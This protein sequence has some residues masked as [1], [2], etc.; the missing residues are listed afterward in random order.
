[1]KVGWHE[2]ESGRPVQVVQDPRQFRT[3]DPRHDAKTW[4]YRTTW[5][6]RKG[7][8]EKIENR[9]TWSN[10]PNFKEIIKPLADKAIFRFENDIQITPTFAGTPANP[11]G[12]TTVGA[13]PDKFWRFSKKEII[14]INDHLMCYNWPPF[15]TSGRTAA[16][17]NG[18]R[19]GQKGGHMGSYDDELLKT[20][21]CF[22]VTD[23]LGD[24][25]WDVSGRDLSCLPLNGTPSSLELT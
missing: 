6:L 25:T 21:G 7:A 9:V 24:F 17:S 22:D 18:R 11:S 15:A 14:T 13:S 19:D 5:A 3:P 2:D 4:P 12:S 20:I 16:G 8:W 1:M 10:L 23:D